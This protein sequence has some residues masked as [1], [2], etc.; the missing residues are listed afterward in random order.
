M[1]S[2]I[3]RILIFAT[4]CTA[5]ISTAVGQPL[6]LSVSAE[7]M[8]TSH[9][10]L[11]N[12]LVGWGAE[13]RAPFGQSHVSGFVRI[14]KL[15]ASGDRT[16]APCA[17]L[18]LEGMCPVQTIHDD[19]DYSAFSTG[20]VLPLFRRDV[21]ELGATLTGI[22][23]KPSVFSRGETTGQTLNADKVMFG[24]TIGVAGSWRPT[25]RLPVSVDAGVAI[26]GLHP[27]VTDMV[28]DGYAP[29]EDDFRITTFR[30]GLSVRTRS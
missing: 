14:Q 27:I 1:S 28:V 13:V 15:S 30:I 4:V 29:F 11:A 6:F 8:S 25:R 17:G 3:A 19:A 5:P 22:I 12:T 9:P 16:G 24:A 21:F 18:V 7:G 2:Q 10:L 23:A 20:L 26:G